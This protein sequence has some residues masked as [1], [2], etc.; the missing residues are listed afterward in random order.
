MWNLK[1]RAN[2]PI[3]RA[4][5]ESQTWRTDCGYQGGGS[6]MNRESGLV[7]ANDYLWSG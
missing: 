1:R 5:T 2:E 6:W 7:S 3:H 4:E